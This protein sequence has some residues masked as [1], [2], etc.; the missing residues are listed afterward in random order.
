MTSARLIGA[1][2]RRR[3]YDARTLGR[4]A[5]RGKAP[6][7]GCREHMICPLPRASEVAALRADR[8]IAISKYGGR[9]GVRHT[10]VVAKDDPAAAAHAR[11]GELSAEDAR[12]HAFLHSLAS[13]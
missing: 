3:R 7:F 10:R 8:G 1:P 4:Q 13:A 5:G 2:P 6:D 11:V 9:Q 12:V